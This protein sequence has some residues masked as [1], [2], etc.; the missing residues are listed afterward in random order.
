MSSKF[1]ANSK[2]A[3][4]PSGLHQWHPVRFVSGDP[5]K[6]LVRDSFQMELHVITSS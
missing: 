6:D 3:E 4:D 2:I 5:W 1:E